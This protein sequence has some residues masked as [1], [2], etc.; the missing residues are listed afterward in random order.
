[1]KRTLSLKREVLTRLTGDE[2]AMV[3]GGSHLCGLTD[4][5]TH[6][7]SFDA[8]CPTVPLNA[9]SLDLRCIADVR[10]TFACL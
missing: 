2:L 5:C 6:G 4:P 10:Q 7:A 3:V 8:A 9:C 1:M